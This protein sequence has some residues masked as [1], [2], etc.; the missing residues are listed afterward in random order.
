MPRSARLRRDADVLLAIALAV[1]AV[2]LAL[3]GLTRVA[4]AAVV[5]ALLVLVAPGYAM[6]A[7]LFPQAPSGPATRWL[8][9]LGTS[10]CIAVLGG[11]LLNAAPLGLTPMAWTLL[12]GA[13][14]VAAGAVAISLRGPTP[15]PSLRPALP[16]P[17]NAA[18]WGAAVVVVV[19]AF[20]IDLRSAATQ[21]RPGFTQL[22]LL[23][24]SGAPAGTVRLGVRNEEGG[25]TV[26]EVRLQSGGR[27]VQRWP[28]I[29]LKPDESWGA[30]VA[31][32]AGAGA[33]GPVEVDLYRG[34]DTSAPYRHAIL[35]PGSR[36][37]S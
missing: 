2:A 13:V 37:G 9:T 3:L 17:R 8:L 31:L 7:A 4:P 33:A 10:L 12:L 27:T 23:P 24:A 34:G 20:V 35:S 25:D 16:S 36:A 18:F 28:A 5:G 32:P 29:T 22:W 6:Q 21:P 15:L 26:Y 14:T 19:A 11:F 30:T 1:I